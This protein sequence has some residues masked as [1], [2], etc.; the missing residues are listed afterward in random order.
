MLGLFKMNK[1]NTPLIAGI[2]QQEGLTYI[3]EAH[4]YLKIGTTIIDCTFP[5]SY[6]TGFIKDIMIETEINPHQ[7]TDHKIRFH[8]DHL[9]KWL[10]ASSLPFSLQEL[11]Q[12]RE[13]CIAA[14]GT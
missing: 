11:W 13:H 14:L 9:E 7:I 1:H 10:K 12:I 6:N 5:G 2:L 4:N 8:K 3:P